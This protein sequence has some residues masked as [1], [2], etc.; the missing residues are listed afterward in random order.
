M[1]TFVVLI[2]GLLRYIGWWLTALL[3]WRDPRAPMRPHRFAVLLFGMPVFMIIQL[4]HAI[5]LLLDEV[6]FFRFRRVSLEGTVIITGIPRSGTTFLHRTLAVNNTHYTTPRT[7]EALLAPSILQ[8]RLI[9]ALR[10]IDRCIGRPFGRLLT[11]LTRRLTGALNDIHEVGLESAE[12]DYL[13]LLPAGGCFVMLLAF[14]SAPGLQ[15]LG[16][17]DRRMPK[18]RRRRL[19]RFHR[20]C[21]QRHIHADG[22]RRRL[23]S[24][25]AAFGSWLHGLNESIPEARFIFCIREPKRA[26]SSQISSIHPARSLFGTATDATSLQVLF[27]DMFASTLSD[28]ASNLATWP[29]DRAVIIDMA[30]LRSRQAAVIREAMERLNITE[31]DSLAEHLDNLGGGSGS[32]HHHRVDDLALDPALMDE[33]LAG[34]YELL[35][36]MPHR[37]GRV[38]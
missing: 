4:F 21:L 37:A 27:L 2:E 15:A 25:N 22:G 16:H 26:L 7:W 14:P 38:L 29:L 20:A 35:L 17:L 33:R 34:N 9:R 30:D 10:L 36:T 32:T 12:E 13:F 28:L 5:C 19:L 31:D 6:L 24:K 18:G 8:R 23:L 11:V 3:R 1:N